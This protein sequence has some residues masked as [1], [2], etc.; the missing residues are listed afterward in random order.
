[1]M[2]VRPFIQ[3]HP[4]LVYFVLTFALGWGGIL[5]LTG[6]LGP[7]FGPDWRSDPRFMFGLLAGPVVIAC[8]GLAMTGLTAGRAGYRELRSRLLRW[9]V[10]VGWYALAFLLVPFLTMAA[11]VLLALVLRAPEFLP[12][13]FTAQ[14]PLGLLLPGIVTG[15]WVGFFEELGWTGFAVPWLRRRHGLLSTGLL[16]GVVWGALH[17]PLFRE[18]G[19]FSGVLPLA[20]LLVKLFSWLPAFRV[21]LVWVHDRTGS[22]V[23]PMLMHASMSAT[24]IAL[25]LPTLSPAQSLTSILASAAAWWVVVAAVSVANRGQLPQRPPE[26]RVA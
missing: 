6:G 23:V 7:M 26:L 8:A 5:L 10:G 14:D 24:S 9:R 17:F 2:T 19:S 1:M 20:V 3:K 4:V 15:L 18:S 21:L 16:V 12:A 11:A 25:A 22:L 13:I